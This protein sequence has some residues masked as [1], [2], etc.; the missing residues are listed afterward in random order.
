M[1]STHAT[2]MFSSLQLCKFINW[3]NRSTFFL[4]FLIYGYRFIINKK[5]IAQGK[6]DWLCLLTVLFIAKNTLLEFEFEF[7]K[8]THMYR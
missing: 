7:I 8:I 5:M 1:G 6:E 3:F 4:S 2:G